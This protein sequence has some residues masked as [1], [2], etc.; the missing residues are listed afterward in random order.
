MLFRRAR[1]SFLNQ[2][3][4]QFTYFAYSHYDREISCRI[5]A[6]K[7]EWVVAVDI[8]PTRSVVT[9]R[10]DKLG[11]PVIQ[12][13]SNKRDALQ[14]YCQENAIDLKTVLYVGN[15]IND[16]DVMQ[17]VTYKVCP[18]DAV[19]SIRDISDIVL[20]SN[21]GNGVIRELYDNFSP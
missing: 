9:K 6:Q 7:F 3:Q 1:S 19:G 4:Q 2:L 11:I 12:G 8:N 13:S 17:C 14:G 10:A 20:K 18:A 16:Y 5:S 21:G 15:D